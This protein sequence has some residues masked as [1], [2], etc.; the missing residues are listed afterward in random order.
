[1]CNSMHIMSKHHWWKRLKCRCGLRESSGTEPFFRRSEEPAVSE[2]EG[3]SRV[4]SVAAAPYFPSTS[5]AM[6][7]NCMFD[8]PS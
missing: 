3:I 7:A 6:V 2:V 8:V 1:M 4:E 5:L